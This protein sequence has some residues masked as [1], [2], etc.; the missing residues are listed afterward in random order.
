MPGPIQDAQ[1]VSQSRQTKVSDASKVPYLVASH[2]P[3]MHFPGFSYPK[4]IF[5]S[6]E[7]HDKQ[8]FS[9]GPEQSRH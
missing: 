2:V 8:S 5:T 1:D 7:L 6:V 9:V 4:G 3:V